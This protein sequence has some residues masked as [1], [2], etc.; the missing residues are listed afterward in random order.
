M[1]AVALGIV[2]LVAVAGAATVAWALLRDSGG[3]R[4]GDDPYVSALEDLCV[5]ARS[6]IEALGRPTDTPIDVVYPGTVRIGRAMLAKAGDLTPPEGKRARAAQFAH[7]YSLYLDGLEYAH[8]YLENQGN[9]VAFVQIVNG[10]LANLRNAERLAVE[11]GAPNCA[12][13]P[14]E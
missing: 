12:V 10:A 1:K 2:L 8:H 9:Q 14:F 7:Q 13:R 11:L 4:D 6:E 5:G 3:S